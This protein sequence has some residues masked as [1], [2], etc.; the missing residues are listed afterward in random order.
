MQYPAKPSLWEK[1]IDENSRTIPIVR[2]KGYSV[3]SI[4]GNMKLY[5][6]DREE[7]L[8][9]YMGT[10]TEEELDAAIAY[11]WAYP[12]GIDRKLWEIAN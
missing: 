1:Y 10:L 2:D 9:G 4:I 3:W 12:E 6:G 5:R 7:V 11:Y 8:K